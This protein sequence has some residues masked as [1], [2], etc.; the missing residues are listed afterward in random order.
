MRKAKRR[1]KEFREKEQSGVMLCD[2]CRNPVKYPVAREKK[3]KVHWI[4][5]R[6]YEG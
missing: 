4:C 1:N 3:G 5:R 2:Y 6:C